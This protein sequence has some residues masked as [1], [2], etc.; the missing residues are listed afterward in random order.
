MVARLL[1]G[2][3]LF[4]VDAFGEAIREVLAEA[5]APGGKEPPPT[6]NDL[7]KALFLVS[8]DFKKRRAQVY[9][10]GELLDAVLNSAAFPAVFRGVGDLNHNATVDGG[11]CENLPVDCLL[12]EQSEFGPIIAI[13]LPPRDAII[14][15]HNF[16]DYGLELFKTAFVQSVE[17]VRASLPEG[18]ILNVESTLGIFDFPAA[19]TD[20]EKRREETKE[21]ETRAAR[22]LEDNIHRYNELHPL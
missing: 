12:Q 11:L 7:S 20:N 21:T 3:T 4:S 9:N 15:I 2:D 22:W 14:P 13:S 17:R 16:L 1:A 19:F 18:A 6:F 5:R 10:D 8:T